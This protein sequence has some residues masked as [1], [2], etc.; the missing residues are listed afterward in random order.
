MEIPLDQHRGTLIKEYKLQEDEFRKILSESAFQLRETGKLY[1]AQLAG[2][3]ELRGNVILRLSS[4]RPFP[5][6]NEHLTALVPAK[7]HNNPANWQSTNY[8]QIRGQSQRFCE[9][10]P[11]LTCWRV[12]YWRMRFWI[13]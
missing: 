4:K 6:K 11:V 10:V 2:F 7:I 12:F 1:V 3:D 8:E 5:R 9:L 13:F